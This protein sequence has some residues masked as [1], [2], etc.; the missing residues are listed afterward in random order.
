[1]EPEAGQNPQRGGEHRARDRLTPPVALAR[2]EMEQCR[3]PADQPGDEEGQA[4]H[5]PREGERLAET[6]DVGE[7]LAAA[8]EGADDDDGERE[9]DEDHRPR[10]HRQ[11]E[12]PA[13]PPGTAIRDAVG[14]VER[15][16]D[17]R[18]RAR[19]R[20]QRGGRGGGEQ[21]ATAVL[22]QARDR[23]DGRGR[24]RGEDGVQRRDELFLH[25]GCQ[26]GTDDHVEHAEQA[27]RDQQCREDAEYG[28]ERGLCGEPEE[29][30]LLARR[31]ERAEAGPRPSA[32]QRRDRGMRLQ[33]R[34]D[35]LVRGAVGRVTTG[36]MRAPP[37]FRRLWRGP[38]V[39]TCSATA[40][41]WVRGACGRRRGRSPAPRGAARP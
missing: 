35:P 18:E 24:L 39:R 21:A 28:E 7:L 2:G 37:P 38:H 25:C 23:R 5:V 14:V 32:P 16:D 19:E 10:A 15:V 29:T 31:H 6:E 11:A 36:R 4:Q 27:C 22:E 8:E 9:N 1:V 30:V 3:R 12:Q 13:P 20:D 41:G 26:R 17:D 34:L 40:S 33:H